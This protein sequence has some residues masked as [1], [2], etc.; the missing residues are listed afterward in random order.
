MRGRGVVPILWLIVLMALTASCNKANST[1][2]LPGPDVNDPDA[3]GAT[4]IAV[5][6]N[7]TLIIGDGTTTSRLTATVRDS[8]G[9]NVGPG[10]SVAFSSSRGRI[11]SPVLTDQN[12]Q[13][14]ATYTSDTGSGAVQV[15][16]SV[17]SAQ[18]IASLSQTSGPASQI[19]LVSV[20]RNSI[21]IRGS[22]DPESATMLFQVRSAQ[23]I[24][25]GSAEAV[26]VDFE[27]VAKT[28]GGE[29][30]GEYLTPTTA[31]SDANGFVS[32]TL[33]SGTIAGA[34]ETIARIATATGSI[35]SRVIPI[36]IDGGLPVV[37]NLTVVAGELNIPGMCYANIRSPVLALVF[38]D[39]Q[40][41]V[42][43][44]TIVYFTSQYG[45]IQAADTTDQ[46]GTADVWFI[47]AN[48][49]PP[50]WD[51]QGND[52]YP[53]GFSEIYA[54][55]A[56]ANGLQIRDTT[57]V[58][59]S[60][61]TRIENVSPAS[62]IVDNGDCETFTFNLWD[63]NHNPLSAGTRI[64]VSATSGSLSG[65]TNVTL[66]DVQAGYTTFAFA[67]CD[68]DREDL[69]PAAD[70]VISIQVTS[71]NNNVSTLIRGTID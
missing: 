34:T 10:V 28:N 29:G 31:T 24:P 53:F 7:P 47:T 22:G 48:Q 3:G 54:Q 69:D 52:G 33:N 50:V 37:R 40:N 23:G 12:G 56:D 70:V 59:L 51:G 9:E 18:G 20:E 38:D 4:T 64:T 46:H 16:A 66:P 27:L 1:D 63:L 49:L 26:N 39:F 60:G 25:L 35:A 68:D 62:F 45:G 21:G 30:S 41:P 8:D 17:G 44:G 43:E 36:S 42:P 19:V 14:F 58:L 13:A 61:C 2:P 32:T 67:I 57:L 65:D 71:R 15:N 55:T 11:T 6:A 5:A